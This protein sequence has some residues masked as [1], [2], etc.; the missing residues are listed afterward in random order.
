MSDNFQRLVYRAL[1]QDSGAIVD[2]PD[3]S[4]GIE[5]AV[6]QFAIAPAAVA[7]RWRESPHAHDPRVSPAGQPA[8]TALPRTVASCSN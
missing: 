3:V 8:S 6:M 4:A 5:P 7:G 2:H 1:S